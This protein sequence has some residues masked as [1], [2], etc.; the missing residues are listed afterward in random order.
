MK[1]T[2]ENIP[3]LT[4]KLIIVTGANSGLGYWTTFHL[5]SHHAEVIMACRDTIKGKK[6]AE[7][8]RS[9]APGARLHVRKLDLA[10]LD[11]IRVFSAQVHKDFKR[12][13]IL[14]NNAGV[15]AIPERRTRQGFEMQF[16]TNHLGH[17]VLTALLFDLLK[18]KAG[19][20]VVTVSSLMHKRGT[21][22]FEDLNWEKDYSKWKAYG[23][24][25]LANLLFMRE[26]DKKIRSAGKDV[27]S[28]ASHPGWASTNL[29]TKGPSMEGS[30]LMI[31]LNDIGN[32]LLAQS[33]EMGALPTLYAATSPDA[34][35]G[36][37]YG[38][39]GMSGLRGFPHEEKIDPEKADMDS[40]KKLWDASEKLTGIGFRVN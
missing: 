32:K 19:S 5:A 8:I 1:W 26:L 34:E 29:Q 11:S 10:D 24:S 27:L 23:Q 28:L 25:K 13:D 15:M 35:G 6:A 17:F 38:P 7:K 9:G 12:L 14:V 21:I 31:W 36:R 39:S 18:K 4:G 20:R 40:A 3:D 33:A 2:F 37:Y 22:R 16:G 30:K